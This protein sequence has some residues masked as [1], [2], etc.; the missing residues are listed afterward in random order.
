M[1]ILPYVSKAIGAGTLAL[2]GYETI[3]TAQRK[4]NM[5]TKKSMGK[6][7]ADLYISHQSSGTESGIINDLK[8]KYREMATDSK[9]Y[10]FIVGIGHFFSNFGGNIINSIVPIGLGVGALLSNTRSGFLSGPV[11]RW[12]SGACAIGLGLLASKEVLSEVLG[13]GKGK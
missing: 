5:E 3:E 6:D 11:P 9:E 13:I 7:L 4:A 2:I 1:S 10:P 12:I 8:K